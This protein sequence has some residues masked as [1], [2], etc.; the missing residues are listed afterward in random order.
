MR[1]S[2]KSLKAATL[3]L[4]AILLASCATW[5]KQ[6]PFKRLAPTD[7]HKSVVYVYNFCDAGEIVGSGNN[8]YIDGE[9]KAYLAQG[10]Y[11]AQQVTAGH[12]VIEWNGTDTPKLSFELNTR[13]GSTYYLKVEEPELVAGDLYLGG[14]LRMQLTLVPPARGA[15]EVSR[16]V[17]GK[18]SYFSEADAF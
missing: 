18:K 9:R 2:L 15:A 8:I 7:H 4:A 13:P 1:G 17:V 16:C 5:G 6:T 12:H 3:C 14:T 10:A 11:Y